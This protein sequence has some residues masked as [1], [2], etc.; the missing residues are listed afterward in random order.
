MTRWLMSLL[1]LSGLGLLAYP[2]VSAGYEVITVANGGTIVGEVKYAGDPPAPEKIPVTK[3]E[4]ICGSE[5]KTSP[6][7]LVGPDKGIKDAV[8]RLTDIQKGKAPGKPEK[9]PVLDQKS[10]EY[11]P[12]AQLIPVNTTLEI[13][14]SDDVL[15]NVKTKGASKTQFNMAQPKFKR[16][17]TYDFKNPEIVQVECNVHGWMHAVLVVAEHPYYALTDTNGS[18]KIAD[19]PPGKY[20]LKVWHPILGE[21]TKEVT[22]SEKEEAKVAFELKR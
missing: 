17:L 8:L 13:V 9:A 20:T 2:G 3:D 15:H 12:Y 6:D 21:Q 10:C 4:K 18:F 1:A 5:P 14:N 11:H 19:V 7:L 16:K 22:V